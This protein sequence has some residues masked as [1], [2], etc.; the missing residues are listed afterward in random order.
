MESG[1]SVVE[2][3][4]CSAVM[5]AGIFS[6]SAMSMPK[7]VFML[8]ITASVPWHMRQAARAA[9]SM[10]CWPCL[11]IQGPLSSIELLIAFSKRASLRKDWMEGPIEWNSMP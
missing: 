10:I 2:L 9:V 5:I 4:G 1:N 8:T 11:S 7:L 6:A 3:S